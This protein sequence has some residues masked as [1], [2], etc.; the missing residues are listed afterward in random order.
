MEDQRFELVVRGGSTYFAPV[1]ERE[2]SMISNF[3]KW[4]QAFRIYSTIL[5]RTYPGRASE[6]IQYNHIIYTASLSFTWDNVYLYDKEF[7]MHVS[8]FPQH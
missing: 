1:S 8:K 7:R 6:F 4:E 2:R 5:T 3:S